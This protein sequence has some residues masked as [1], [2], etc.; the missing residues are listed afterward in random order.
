MG[1]C[2]SSRFTLDNL[3]ED[4]LGKGG[5]TVPDSNRQATAETPHRGLEASRNE[6]GLRFTPD[7]LGEDGL[8]KDGGTMPDLN[9]QATAEMPHEE[10]EPSKNELGRSTTT[11]F[12]GNISGGTGGLGGEGGTTGGSGGRGEGP[13]FFGQ[14][15]IF[16]SNTE[17]ANLLN[18]LGLKYVSARYNATE[19]T[20][21]KCMEG[22]RVK[23][24]EDIIEQLTCPPN[25][26]V[27]LVL[28]SG[29]AGSGKSTIAKTV[30]ARLEEEKKLLAASF[31]FSRNSAERKEIKY[32][33]STLA[34]Q[35][36]D[37]N[38]DFQ[39]LL[40]TL[41]KEDRSRL[42]HADPK[43]QFQK[44]VVELLA[45]MPSSQMPWVI[46]LDALDE[47]GK[48]HGKILLQW[49]SNVIS[50]IPV[51]IR[52]FLTGRPEVR[53]H[54]QLGCDHLLPLCKY[55]NIEAIDSETARED[56]C[57]YVTRS[58]VDP[59]WDWIVND[60]DVVKIIN[61]ADGLFIFAATVV[62]YVLARS[63]DDIPPQE[64]VDNLL[65]KDAHLISLD[66]LYLQIIEEVIGI[67]NAFE[68][69]KRVLGAIV[70]LIEPQDIKTLA[71]LLQI[72]IKV[73][74]RTLVRLSA[75]LSVPDHDSKGVIKIMHL[76][77]REFLIDGIREKQPGLLC[78]TEAQQHDLAHNTFC[79][80]QKE[81]KFNICH[82][83]TSH[84]RNIDIPD[85]EECK[86]KYIPGH[87]AYSCRFWAAHLATSQ[88][89]PK[90]AQDAHGF[91][92]DHFL[93]WL[94][95]LSLISAVGS[96]MEILSKFIKWGSQDPNMVEIVEFA[97]DGIRFINFFKD[98]IVQSAP[99]I[100]L[101]ALALAPEQSHIVKQFCPQF[102]HLLSAGIGRMDV[103]PA[104]ILVLEMQD[105]VRSV[106]FSPDG[107]WI[108]SG[109]WDNTVHVW[110]AESGEVVAGPFNGH[111]DRVNSVAFSPDGKWIVSGSKD[112]TVRVW[113]AESGEVVA[114]P[115]N[116]HTGGVN[117]V[118]FSPDGKQIVSGSADNTVC[119]WDAESGE[120]VAGPFNGHAGWVSSVAFS[121]DGRQIVSG[122]EDSTV[123][124]WDAESGQV[125]AGP[126]NGH[127]DLVT[128]VA[129]SPDGKWIVSGSKDKT[130][131]VWDA[132]IGEVVAGPFNGHTDSVLS[133]AFSPDGKQIV[134]GSL[135]N[136][137]CIWDTEIGVVAGLL[138]GHTNTVNSVMFSSNGRRIVSGSSDYTLR[139]WDAESREAAADLF[140]GHTNQVRSVAF[141]P[142]GKQ[143]VSGS[144]DK[145]VC[146][147]D[148]DSGEVVAGPFA[149]HTDQVRSV[150]FSPDGKQVISGSDDKTVRVWDA[151]SG[152]VVAGPFAGHTDQV[153][154]VAFSPNGKHIVSGS[155]DKTLHVWD[156][157]SGKIVA[158]PL[159]G[160][161]DQVRS[162]AFS[163]N[164]K[165]I[166]SG[167]KDNT[168]YVWDADSGEVVAGP[169]AG[170][171]GEV[172]SVAFSP[173]GK[174][175]VSGSDDKTVCVWDAKSGE[176]VAGPFNG[177][178]YSVYSVAFSPDGKW[179]VSG[180]NDTIVCVWA[181]EDGVDIDLFFGH[182]H[183]V[184][185]VAFSPNG[186]QIVSGSA[187]STVRVWDL[188]D[189]KAAIE[190]SSIVSQKNHSTMS[191]F[192]SLNATQPLVWHV[193]QGWL[194][195]RL[196]E[197][198]VWLPNS[199]REGLWSPHNTLVI[200]KQQTTLNFDKFVHGTEW[201]H[202]YNRLVARS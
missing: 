42:V 48:D 5:R 136:T 6:L 198:L 194:C 115:F 19:T 164:G 123:H 106:A 44:M 83:P 33:P 118:A 37:Y 24:I 100:Y 152:E 101:S 202:C 149:G 155:S 12:Y 78:G 201:T 102:P 107:K 34:H 145:T 126:F 158:G 111:T 81:L 21:E 61:R 175:I 180:S 56:I 114:G 195:C 109:S 67:T 139:V 151:K 146:V 168:M 160:H 53:D 134:S 63:Q 182:T 191:W 70:E 163:P 14:Q 80:M 200:G 88:Y 71:G 32:L 66:D 3:G 76:S 177:H 157:K 130:V 150:A 51:F 20:A 127:T 120:V 143:I 90:L 190:S 187:D 27:R 113:D 17:T 22:T 140:V 174:Q 173:D 128:S 183:C 121:P 43:E 110:N 119:V 159:A 82:L 46:C 135:D 35:L 98:P 103:W 52:F 2:F 172:R 31:F 25:P 74:R 26:S 49:L 170:H 154:S 41:L 124:V 10:L 72:D 138:N 169:F 73:L 116:G 189:G 162:V 36:A 64:S 47:C 156:A 99:H 11:H 39:R 91:L 132:D 144:D 92:M 148:A 108:V 77:F 161:T 166:V 96:A 86:Q 153:R 55:S 45:K 28:C 97:R 199:L 117:S 193:T 93:F 4:G 122:Y 9:S 16:H 94:E 105:V 186:M 57:L 95:V 7:N 133:V 185:S 176:V 68:R 89:S 167:S 192:Q 181:V 179:V 79:I 30:A 40:V 165:Q 59:T 38:T 125:V 137:V 50:D 188:E 142:D 23:I 178:I 29:P 62:R 197:L 8:H 54:L 87:L 69:T 147:W 131:C 13:R 18:D 15:L 196:S 141:S 129:F 65:Q 84:V 58:L 85:L 60:Q 75:V 184:N 1:A 112:K 104:T 171:T